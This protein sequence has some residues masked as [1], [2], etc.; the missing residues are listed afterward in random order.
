MAVPQQRRCSIKNAVHTVERSLDVMGLINVSFRDVCPQT[1]YSLSTADVWFR[2][3]VGCEM[4]IQIMPQYCII[5]HCVGLGYC[6]LSPV[7]YG[8][9]WTCI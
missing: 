1:A 3:W 9:E 8:R 7:V 5:W 4:S 2:R 6:V